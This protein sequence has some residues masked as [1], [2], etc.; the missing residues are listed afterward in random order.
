MK[1]EYMNKWIYEY[2]INYGLVKKIGENSK[3]YLPYSL[4]IK[5]EEI[6]KN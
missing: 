4:K 5:T 1:D 2:L 3:N 6:I